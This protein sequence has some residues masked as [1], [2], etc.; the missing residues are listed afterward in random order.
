[1]TYHL[2]ALIT[3]YVICC[4]Y[5]CSTVHHSI[6]VHLFKVKICFFAYVQQEPVQPESH[7]NDSYCTG[8]ASAASLCITSHNVPL[9][10]SWTQHQ[11]NS[12][13]NKG[14]QRVITLC[15]QL[16]DNKTLEG[17]LGDVIQFALARVQL[18]Y[19]CTSQT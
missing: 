8:S 6:T 14:H 17:T 10:N 12:A 11:N 7:P 2:N 3:V 16:G 19:N 18:L 13:P 15:L 9:M 5:S 1:M 4:R